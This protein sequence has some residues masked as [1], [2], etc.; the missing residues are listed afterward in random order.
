MQ[1]DLLTRLTIVIPTYQ[2]PLKALRAMRF[3]ANKQVKVLVL[4]GCDEAM[5]LPDDI[6]AAQN[7]E[8]LHQPKALNERL[9]FAASCVTSDYVALCGDDDFHLPS[10]LDAAIRFLDAHPDY[11]ACGGQM[12]GFTEPHF[13]RALAFEKYELFRELDF[14]QDDP[15]AR[16]MAYFRNYTPASIYSVCRKDVW[17]D[18]MMLWGKREFPVYVI[19]ELQ[20]EFNAVYRGKIK[21]LPILQWLRSA[22]LGHGEVHSRRTGK[23]LSLSKATRLEKIWGDQSE[24]GLKM[25]IVQYT[26]KEISERTGLIDSRIGRDFESALSLYVERRKKKFQ[27]LYP[28]DIAERLVAKLQKRITRL[29]LPIELRLAMLDRRSVSFDKSEVMDVWRRINET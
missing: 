4:D 13:L 9:A 3:W 12:L 18:G 27:L 7:I 15:R 14:L 16:A 26:A 21:R 2:R 24:L 29:K 10:S 17:C 23:D 1:S 11:S 28:R 8:Y 20:F 5:D 6:R 19:G 22:K 25:Q